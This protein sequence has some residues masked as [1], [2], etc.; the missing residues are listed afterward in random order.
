MNKKLGINIRV[1]EE[2]KRKIEENAKIHN[3][4]SISEF[5]R[6]AGMHIT[7]KGTGNAKNV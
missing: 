2:E 6:F 3:F 1:T 5:L 4:N 7:I